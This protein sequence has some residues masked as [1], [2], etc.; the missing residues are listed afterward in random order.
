[1]TTGD[2]KRVADLLDRFVAGTVGVEDALLVSA[3]GVGLAVSDGLPAAVADQF[4]AVAAGL[5]SLTR[6]AARCFA[7][8]RAKGVVIEL[9]QSYLLVS[10]VTERA[11]LGVV[12]R[13]D[14][15]IESA[16]LNRWYDPEPV[17][18]RF[19]RAVCSGPSPTRW[20]RK[21]FPRSRN[22]SQASTR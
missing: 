19:S 18:T 10:E 14:A 6:G 5:V 3:D 9:D 22:R 1:M 8:E 12:A 4:G 13:A 11:V 17:N 16:L 20:Q 7:E 2:S 15:D 21:R